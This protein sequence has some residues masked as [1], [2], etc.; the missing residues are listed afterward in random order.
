MATVT[1]SRDSQAYRGQSVWVLLNAADSAQLHNFHINQTCAI[2]GGKTGYIDFIDTYGHS[3]RIKP[4]MPINSF[5]TQG[6]EGYLS[7][8]EVIT[9]S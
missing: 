6:V 1:N 4:D 5:N 8:S 2:S 3:L 9:I 7:N